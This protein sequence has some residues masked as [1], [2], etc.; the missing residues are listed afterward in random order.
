[1]KISTQNAIRAEYLKALMDFFS[2]KEEDVGQ[3]ESNA[4]N[5]PIVTED[6]EEGFIEVW[7]K[8]PKGDGDDQ[9]LKR[10]AYARKVEENAEKARVKAEEKAKKIAK[11]KAN[12]E[13]KTKAKAERE[14]GV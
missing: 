6:G 12:R 4:F 13:A 3:I 7:V 2:A 11:D 10:D 9:F 1:M 14:A 8:M 5:F